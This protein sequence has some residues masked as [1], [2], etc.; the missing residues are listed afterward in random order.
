MHNRCGSEPGALKGSIDTRSSGSQEISTSTEKSNSLSRKNFT[1]KYTEIDTLSHSG[2]TH[3]KMSHSLHASQ[4][5]NIHQSSGNGSISGASKPIPP[6]PNMRTRGRSDSS[7]H[8]YYILEKLESEAEEGR[9]DQLKGPW[10]FGLREGNYKSWSREG[11]KKN[12][13]GSLKR[14]VGSTDASI[15]NELCWGDGSIRPRSG[16]CPSKERRGGSLKR[17]VSSREGSSKSSRSREGSVKKTTPIN[18]SVRAAGSREGS[19]KSRGSRDGS[20]KKEVWVPVRA[21]SGERERSEKVP[22]PLRDYDVLEPRELVSTPFSIIN[23]NY[24]CKRDT[25]GAGQI[26]DDP[27][28]AAVSVGDLPQL[29]NRHQSLDPIIPWRMQARQAAMGTDKTSSSKSLQDSGLGAGS[30]RSSIYQMHNTTPICKIGM[31]VGRNTPPTSRLSMPF[32]AY[33]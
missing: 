2:S 10:E 1:H 29:A 23:E 3:S 14:E 11:S 25:D 16:S 17:V 28:Y 4:G 6:P 22:P 8:F 33:S 5:D 19:I 31:T 27:K 12:R 9:G 15:K 26:F 18:G 32:D 24:F 20:F 13:S 30:M 21:E 7:P